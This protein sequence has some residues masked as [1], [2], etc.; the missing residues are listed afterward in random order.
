MCLYGQ[1]EK[2]C[3]GGVFVQKCLLIIM[4]PLRNPDVEYTLTF[5]LATLQIVEVASFGF[6]LV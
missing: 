1:I 4:L 3:P 6:K 5:M 2:L